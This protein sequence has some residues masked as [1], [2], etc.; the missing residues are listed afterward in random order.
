MDLQ[1]SQLL[2]LRVQGDQPPHVSGLIAVQQQGSELLSQAVTAQV[3]PAAVIAGLH[4]A[5][6]G[7]T[8]H[9]GVR[10]RHKSSVLLAGGKHQPVRDAVIREGLD[11]SRLPQVVQQHI[12]DEHAVLLPQPHHRQCVPVVADPGLRHKPLIGGH[13]KH[14]LAHVRAVS[15][16]GALGVPP[17]RRHCQH[18]L[19]VQGGGDQG[20]ILLRLQAEH[21]SPL[22]QNVQESAADVVSRHPAAALAQGRNGHLHLGGPGLPAV[23]VQKPQRVV[24]QHHQLVPQHREA[25]ARGGVIAVPLLTGTGGAAVS[26]IPPQ[27]VKARAV[28]VGGRQHHAQ[29]RRQGQKEH[30]KPPQAAGAPLR[31]SRAVVVIPDVFCP[32]SH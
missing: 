6:V 9:A 11:F 3:R 32:V 14:H 26:E 18:P 12:A 31:P 5:R 22:I 25:A 29:H 24:R 10:Y 15:G 21:L 13:V 16:N 23:L 30:E 8:G 4:S 27:H 17:L 20:L 19:G 1:A 28:P 2:A 7:G